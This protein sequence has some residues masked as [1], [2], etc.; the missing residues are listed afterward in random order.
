MVC[1]HDLGRYDETSI[2]IDVDEVIATCSISRQVRIFRTCNDGDIGPPI[3]IS[4]RLIP[5]SASASASTF[6]NNESAN[7]VAAQTPCLFSVQAMEGNKRRPLQLNLWYGFEIWLLLD[8]D[9]LPAKMLPPLYF[10]FM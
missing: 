10:L 4:F 6:I 2:M 5:T 9:T 1:S 7:D 8:Q 3:R